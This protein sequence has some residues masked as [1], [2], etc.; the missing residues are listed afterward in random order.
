MTKIKVFSGGPNDLTK[1]T[2]EWIRSKEREGF[3]VVRVSDP[4]PQAMDNR[5]STM[6]VHMTTD[7]ETEQFVRVVNR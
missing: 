5:Y 2:N 7:V 6:I 3:R 4:A 1:E